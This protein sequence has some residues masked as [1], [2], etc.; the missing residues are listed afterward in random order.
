MQTPRS[1]GIIMHITSLPSAYGIGDLGPAAYEFADFLANSSFRFWQV[2]PL[3]STDDGSGYSPYSALSAF[4]GNTLMISPEMLVKDNLLNSKD[5]IHPVPFNSNKVDFDTIHQFKEPLF[6]KAFQYFKKNSPDSINKLFLKFL[7]ENSDWLDD[8]ALYT[9]IRAGFNKKSW[10]DWPANLRD[11]QPEALENAKAEHAEAILKEKFLQFLFFRQLDLLKAYCQ[12]RKVY[13]I[14]DMPFYVSYE[15]ADVWAHPYYFMLTDTMKPAYSGGVPPDDFSKTGQMWGMPTYDWP[16]LQENNFSWW[17]KRIE[18]NLRMC[19]VLRLDHFRAFSAFWQ[20][21]AT[22]KTAVNGKWIKCPGSAFFKVIRKEYPDMPFI[23]EDL[24]MIDQP[25]IDLLNEFDFAGMRI[26]Q[27]GF[28]HDLGTNPY[29]QHNHVKNS[30]VYTG[31]HDNNTMRGWFETEIPEA[32]KKRIESYVNQKV[33]AA[34]IHTVGIR[35]ALGSVGQVAIF[36]VQDLLGLGK[37]AI[38]NRPGTSH[39][40]WNWRIKS[41]LLTPALA[42]KTKKLLQIFGRANDQES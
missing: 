15:S 1:S 35:L 3:N 6:E 7:G 42:G 23:A 30:I 34:T 29:I 10:S 19:D 22:N 16:K 13:F 38:M 11:R 2:L 9:A 39:N 25:V 20:I 18:Q 14:G 4:A 36:P 28:G 32:T 8:Y 17:V 5:L 31:T 27:F 33:S 21:K 24:G 40:N 41:G 37:E 12:E 26:I